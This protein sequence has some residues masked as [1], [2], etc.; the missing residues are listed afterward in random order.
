VFNRIALTAAAGKAMDEPVDIDP[1][2]IVDVLM[3][4]IDF[5]PCEAD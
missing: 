5:S 3:H 2:L 1:S 4:L